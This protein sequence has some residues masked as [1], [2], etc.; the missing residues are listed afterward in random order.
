MLAA[1]RHWDDSLVNRHYASI[2]PGGAGRHFPFSL[3][4]IPRTS[5]RLAE[6]PTEI[7]H[8]WLA[9]DKTCFRPRP[10]WWAFQSPPPLLRLMSCDSEVCPDG[11][12]NGMVRRRNGTRGLTTGKRVRLV[13]RLHRPS[14]YWASDGRLRRE[15]DSEETFATLSGTTKKGGK[16]SQGGIPRRY[17]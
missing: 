10:F 1:S 8:R 3:G 9:F 2:M 17:T 11:E 15:R 12:A 14:P 13:P 6:S 4:P 7:R 5:L 16:T